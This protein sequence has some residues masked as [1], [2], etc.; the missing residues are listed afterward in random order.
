MKKICHNHVESE[1][2][3]CPCAG[4]H[5]ENSQCIIRNV[6][7]C[8]C[9][10]VEEEMSDKE[11]MICDMAKGNECGY[12]WTACP[13]GHREPHEKSEQCYRVKCVSDGGQ[14]CTIDCVPVEEP[15]LE[16]PDCATCTHE[17][18]KALEPFDV[19]LR[20]DEHSVWRLLEDHISIHSDSLWGIEIRKQLK[21]HG[22]ES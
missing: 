1:C 22:I 7:D 15:T 6:I 14:C 11:M 12:V 2:G 8:N 10:P 3:S 9:V 21:A 18:E 13:G 5:E 20:V 17:Y 16:A 19:V 4:V